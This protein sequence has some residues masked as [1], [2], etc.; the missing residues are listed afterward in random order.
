MRLYEMIGLKYVDNY[1]DIH[2]G[3]K[4]RPEIKLWVSFKLKQI[5]GNV[6]THKNT[7]SRELI[8]YEFSLLFFDSMKNFRLNLIGQ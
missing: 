8:I 6:M 3:M 4:I 2:S 7:R 5:Q 1:N